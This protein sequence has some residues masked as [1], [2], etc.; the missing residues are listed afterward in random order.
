MINAL[1]DFILIH[2]IVLLALTLVHNASNVVHLQYAL[3]APLDIKLLNVQLVPLDI[4][5][6]LQ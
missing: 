2:P 1:L 5:K 4:I 3:L 6:L